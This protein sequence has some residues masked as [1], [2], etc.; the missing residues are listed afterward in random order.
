M[1]ADWI[2]ETQ[3]GMGGMSPDVTQR[4]DALPETGAVTAAPVREH[5]RAGGR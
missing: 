4:I 5:R 3:F 2:V 1:R